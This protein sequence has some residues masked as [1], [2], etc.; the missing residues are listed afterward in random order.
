MLIM[1]D[2]IEPNSSG[3]YFWESVDENVAV[4]CW[5]VGNE[6]GFA[7]S[8]WKSTASEYAAWVKLIYD[9]A[10]EADRNSK[11]IFCTLLQPQD[12]SFGYERQQASVEFLK[13]TIAF[14]GSTPAFD[15]FNIHDYPHKD[16]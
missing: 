3:G 1:W 14:P 7:R 11:I 6:L 5:Q 12:Y 9:A 10:K 13:E 4:K 16:D 15:V 2:Q 8:E